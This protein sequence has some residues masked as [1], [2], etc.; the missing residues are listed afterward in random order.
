MITVR[1]AVVEDAAAMGALYVRVW[2]DV[3]PGIIPNET[4]LAMCPA[5][6]SERWE[7]AIRAAG[8]RRGARVV[9][10]GS[11]LAGIGNFGPNWDLDLAF[12]GEIF[13]LYVDPDHIGQGAGAALLSDMFATLLDA[14]MS[15]A[16]VWTLSLSPHRFFYEAM[17]AKRV[18]RK[19]ERIAGMPVELSAYGWSDLGAV[20]GRYPPVRTSRLTKDASDNGLASQAG[21][22]A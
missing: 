22:L 2:Q 3:Y 13:T 6:A 4:L 5:V 1:R 10:A 14:G 7:A 18:A 15:S 9:E 20:L 16:L 19:I 17:G 12:D 21:P 8:G 11:A